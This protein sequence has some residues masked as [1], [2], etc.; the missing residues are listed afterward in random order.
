ME[1]LFNYLLVFCLFGIAVGF[2]VL[3]IWER[4]KRFRLNDID[5]PNVE[6]WTHYTTTQSEG[7]IGMPNPDELTG[8]RQGE[9][10]WALPLNSPRITISTEEIIEAQSLRHQLR[11]EMAQV[12][13][14]IGMMQERIRLLTDS[15]PPPLSFP[16]FKTRTVLCFG[17]TCPRCGSI[18]WMQGLEQGQSGTVCTPWTCLSCGGFYPEPGKRVQ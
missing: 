6:K 10:D 18:A 11:G 13:D 4:H 12:R 16:S 15:P 8:I 7:A 17:S 9:F 5:I 14:R 3:T 1:S 2:S